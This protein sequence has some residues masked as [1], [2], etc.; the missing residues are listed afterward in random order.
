MV[1]F[2]FRLLAVFSLAVAVIM[3]VIDATRSIAASAWVSTPLAESWR[4]FSPDTLAAA[5]EFTRDAM[6]PQL[7]D[8][9]ALTLLAAP[10]FAVFAVL[11]LLLYIPGRRRERRGGLAAVRV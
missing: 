11:A 8:P 3:A 10:G 7:W 9:V 6:L 2:F 4:D 1:R 5:E